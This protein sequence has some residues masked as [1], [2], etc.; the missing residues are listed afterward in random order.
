MDV[1]E[2]IVPIPYVKQVKVSIC[3][4]HLLLVSVLWVLFFHGTHRYF[5]VS[6]DTMKS[7]YVIVISLFLN[8]NRF[9]NLKVV[10]CWWKAYNRV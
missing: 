3:I 8:L 9:L 7:L 1:G 6:S 10:K 2:F 4:D 5:F